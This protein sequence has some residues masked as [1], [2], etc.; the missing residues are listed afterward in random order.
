M[1]SETEKARGDIGVEWGEETGSKRKFVGGG[2]RGTATKKSVVIQLQD[3][4][5]TLDVPGR[6]SPCLSV[7][8]PRSV[9]ST[10]RLA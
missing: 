5:V 1:D 10:S 9:R 4:T 7:S 3:K 8:R 2:G 6:R